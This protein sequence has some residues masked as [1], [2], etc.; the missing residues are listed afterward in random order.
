M[1]SS[2]GND[3]YNQLSNNTIGAENAL[4]L[5]IFN[6]ISLSTFSQLVDPTL[7][8]SYYLQL[9]N[10]HTKK[11]YSRNIGKER[12]FWNTLCLFHAIFRVLV[13]KKANMK[14]CLN[15]DRLLTNIGALWKQS[16]VYFTN[17]LHI[18]CCIKKGTLH[19]IWINLTLHYK[20][21]KLQNCSLLINT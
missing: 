4:I 3:L 14:G 16:M 6:S 10:K 8:G 7:C 19:L 13:N 20:K 17:S 2:K 5:K 11:C 18:Q 21:G 15:E 12:F 9:H 1:L